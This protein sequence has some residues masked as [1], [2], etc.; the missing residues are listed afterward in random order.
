MQDSELDEMFK[1]ATKNGFKE[2][3]GVCKV[4]IRKFI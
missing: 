3:S 2:N 4:D 1:D